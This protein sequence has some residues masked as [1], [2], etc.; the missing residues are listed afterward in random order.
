M[1]AIEANKRF[2]PKYKAAKSYDE[3]IHALAEALVCASQILMRSV[4]GNEDLEKPN[5][6]L[7]CECLEI[8]RKG[9]LE[10]LGNKLSFENSKCICDEVVGYA[11]AVYSHLTNSAQSK[12]LLLEHSSKAYLENLGLETADTARRL[13]EIAQKDYTARNTAE[14]LV[15]LCKKPWLIVETVDFANCWKQQTS[16]FNSIPQNESHP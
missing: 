14:V 15:C 13:L 3:L 11:C 4:Q 12:H 1:E 6:R 16:K 5:Y 10:E 9:L 2:A 7:F 8:N